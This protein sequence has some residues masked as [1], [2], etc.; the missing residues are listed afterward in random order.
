MLGA[1]GHNNTGGSERVNNKSC[2]GSE[3]RLLMSSLE[4]PVGQQPLMET[5][6]EVE[7]WGVG[8]IICALKKQ[9]RKEGSRG[10]SNCF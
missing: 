7:R 6:G 9:P 8:H 4:R 2:L 1:A 3:S 10:G 5:G